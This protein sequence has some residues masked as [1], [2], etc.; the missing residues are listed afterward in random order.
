[1][2]RTVAPRLLGVASDAPASLHPLF[3]AG[4]PQGRGSLEGQVEAGTVTAPQPA[5]ATGRLCILS[6][7]SLLLVEDAG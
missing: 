7:V 5:L 4:L 2:H 1:M 3:G 6:G